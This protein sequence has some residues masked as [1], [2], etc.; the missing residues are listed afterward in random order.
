[1]NKKDGLSG[2]HLLAKPTGAICNLG[3]KYCFFLSKKDLYPGSTFRMSDALLESYIRQYIGAQRVPLATVA[4]Q[5]G[6]PTLM[7]LDFFRK[8]MAMVLRYRRPGMIIHNTIQT[9][10]TLIDDEW[11]HFFKENNFL[12]GLSLDGPRKIHDSYRLDKSGGPTFDKVFHAAKLLRRH[13]VDFNILTTVNAANGDSPF[14]VYRFL[15]EEVKA[16]FIQFIPIVERD[17]AGRVTEWSV[18]PEQYG[19]FLSSIF[20]EWVRRDVGKIFVQIFDAS[21]AAWMGAFQSVCI[22]SPTCGTA[23]AMEH[24]GDLY[25]C[26]HFVDRDHLLGNIERV[27]MEK[28]ASSEKQRRF[29]QD[30]L[31]SLPKY[32]LGCEVRFACNGECPKNRFMKAPNG[33]PGLNYLC[34]GYR[35]FFRHVDGPMRFMANELRQGREAAS[36]MRYTATDLVSSAAFKPGRNDP[37]PCG[38]GLKYKKCHGNAGLK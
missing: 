38:S 23:L 9:N 22:F 14:E 1:M 4:W 17:E 25:S 7:G 30:K 33:E 15:R 32:C 31:N 12:V 36:I 2:F 26:D 37:C 19:R 8:A 3:C 21:L 28:L 29:G 20:D 13:K 18:K 24:N 35:E 27:S 10:G 34:A 11:C 5:G 6:E 16:E